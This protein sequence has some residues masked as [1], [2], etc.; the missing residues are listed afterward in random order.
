MRGHAG[1][2][3]PD[4]A[5]LARM[6][7][8]L[9]ALALVD[10]FPARGVAALQDEWGQCLDDLLAIRVGQPAPLG[11][12]GLGPL[13]DR[14]VRSG[15]PGP[16]SGRATGGTSARY[17]LRCRRSAPFRPL[18]LA[19]QRQ[20]A[21]LAGRRCHR[22]HRVDERPIR[23]RQSRSSPRRRSGRSPVQGDVLGVTREMTSRTA[24]GSVLRRSISCRAA[25][26]RAALGLLLV[27]QR[28]RGN[29][30]RAG[31]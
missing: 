1:E 8:A 20:C 7:V 15:L 5:P 13:G 25:S 10:L 31:R 17:P 22:P 28:R 16:A 27:G 21:G 2:V 14:L 26:M 9:G 12:Q 11:Q 18:R 4:L 3:R 6:H 29:P 24:C 30:G 19:E 23:P